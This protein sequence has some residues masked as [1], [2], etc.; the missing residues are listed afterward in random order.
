MHAYT[1][2]QTHKPTHVQ[3]GSW[4]FWRDLRCFIV[5]SGLSIHLSMDSSSKTSIFLWFSLFYFSLYVI[6]NGWAWPTQIPSN[7]TL[8][9]EALYGAVIGRI[10][11]NSRECI[12][13]TIRSVINESA[14][15]SLHTISSDTRHVIRFSQRGFGWCE[16]VYTHRACTNALIIDV[17]ICPVGKVAEIWQKISCVH[18]DR[19]SWTLTR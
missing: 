13:G 3:P 12:I 19:H 6:S 10:I 16:T 14:H 15:A 8:N 9:T 2:E 1:D 11:I 5:C 7:L 18:W 4:E 17:H